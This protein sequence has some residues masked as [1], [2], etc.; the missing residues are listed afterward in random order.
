MATR[1][2][3][4]IIALLMLASLLNACDSPNP[5]PIGLTPIPTLAPGATP[6]LVP[7]VLSQ[8]DLSSTTPGAAGTPDAALGAAVFF[9]HCTLCHGI[10][11]Q[12][13]EAP[14]LRNNTFVQ[15]GGTKV[16]QT[17]ANGRV[18]TIMPAWLQANGG[19]LTDQQINDVIA[20]LQVLQNVPALPTGVPLPTATPF[21]AKPTPVRPSEP[22]NAGQA[23][24]LTGDLS[25]GRALFGKYCSTCHGPQGTRGLLN[26]D[27]DN[28]TVPALNPINPTIANTDP[29][30]FASN[31]DVFIEHGSV[32]AGKTPLLRMPA[33]GDGKLLTPQQIADVIV[34][35]MD[36]NRP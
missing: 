25:R 36:L 31:V 15:T 22:G 23:V 34:Y 6:T 1:A 20:Y 28:G 14:A 2:W 10:N 17:V 3:I 5:Q 26:P 11:G 29:K 9:E 35:V 32:P 12:G 13:A 24:S 4:I 7:A 19:A 16:F 21:P 33:F 18:G 27:S 30:V 8:V